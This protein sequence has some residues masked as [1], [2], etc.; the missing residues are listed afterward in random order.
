[1]LEEVERIVYSHSRCSC[2]YTF[3]SVVIEIVT[4][5]IITTKQDFHECPSFA[6]GLELGKIARI[7]LDKPF[8]AGRRYTC[9]AFWTT[10]K[11]L[12]AFHTFYW[13]LY[14]VGVAVQW[15]FIFSVDCF[16][17]VGDFCLLVNCEV[18]LPIEGPDHHLLQAVDCSW[19]KLS[20]RTILIDAVSSVSLPSCFVSVFPLCADLQVDHLV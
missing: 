2:G 9:L 4:I 12:N 1:M 18:F 17:R 7:A 8:L 5:I 11:F 20:H 19:L 3:N 10:Q 14:L 13:T 15:L 6:F 16:I